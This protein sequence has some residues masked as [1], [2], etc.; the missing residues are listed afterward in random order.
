MPMFTLK[1]SCYKGFISLSIDEK[2]RPNV[3][4]NHQDTPVIQEL[5]ITALNSAY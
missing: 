5:V 2:A 1:S 3:A 4:G